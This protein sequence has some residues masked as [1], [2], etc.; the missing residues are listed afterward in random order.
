MEL[1][2]AQD[3]VN[4]LLD[5]LRIACFHIQSELAVRNEPESHEPGSE[6]LQH[7]INSSIGIRHANLV[8]DE[9][10]WEFHTYHINP[11]CLTLLEEGHNLHLV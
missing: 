2:V 9:A 4:M 11:S 8:D 7:A 5:L 3:I 6:Y 1:P 10:V